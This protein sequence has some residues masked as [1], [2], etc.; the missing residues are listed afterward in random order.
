MQ[1][2]KVPVNRSQNAN[3]IEG[4]CVLVRAF[5]FIF[6]IVKL[7]LIYDFVNENYFFLTSPQ[8]SAYCSFQIYLLR[9]AEQ[10]E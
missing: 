1:L 2:R 7:R 9:P 8:P 4:S 6:L 5:A 3:R 10:F